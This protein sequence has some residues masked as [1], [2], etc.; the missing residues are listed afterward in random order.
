MKHLKAIVFTLAIVFVTSVIIPFVYIVAVVGGLA[1]LA[2]VI[3][4]VTV[5]QMEL[6]DEEEEERRRKG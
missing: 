5:I 1:F 3:Y 6:N 2:F 4:K